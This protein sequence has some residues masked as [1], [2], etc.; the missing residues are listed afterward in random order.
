MCTFIFKA[1]DKCELRSLGGSAYSLRTSVDPSELFTESR[2]TKHCFFPSSVETPASCD[3]WATILQFTSLSRIRFPEAVRP[4]RCANFVRSAVASLRP[5]RRWSSWFRLHR[6]NQSQNCGRKAQLTTCQK[7]MKD[8]RFC[9]GRTLK[10]NGL[11]APLGLEISCREK[12][13]TMKYWMWSF[14]KYLCRLSGNAI[15]CSVRFVR[16]R[17]TILFLPWSTEAP[18]SQLALLRV[19]GN[20]LRLQHMLPHC[21]FVHHL[22]R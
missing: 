5:S 17:D 18:M 8:D 2:V 21:L 12:F 22:C 14:F 7:C 20:L 13:S 19:P 3:T 6:S 4:F 16:A 9:L 15:P 11:P 1:Q 10:M